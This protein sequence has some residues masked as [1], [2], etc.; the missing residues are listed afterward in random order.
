[1]LI[2]SMEI[3]QLRLKLVSRIRPPTW[4]LGAVLALALLDGEGMERRSKDL[5]FLCTRQSP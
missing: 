2:D 3:R 1:M 5:V 4:M